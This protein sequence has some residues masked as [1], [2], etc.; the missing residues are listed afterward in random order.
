MPAAWSDVE[1]LREKDFA[2]YT[3]AEMALARELIARLARRGPT[4]ISRR[5][6]PVA[7]GA[8]T[9]LTF[10]VCCV[11]RCAPAASRSTATGGRPPGDRGRSC[12][13][14]TCRAR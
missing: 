5:T 3:D 6:R 9:S 10:G 2:R 1:L 7:G 8:G 11:L 13:C 14:V 4:R 12:W